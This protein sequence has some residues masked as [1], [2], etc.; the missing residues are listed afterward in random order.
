M[1]LL[2]FFTLALLTATQIA[3]ILMSRQTLEKQAERRVVECLENTPRACS[4]LKGRRQELLGAIEKHKTWKVET[5]GLGVFGSPVFV[6]VRV[7]DTFSADLLCDTNIAVFYVNDE[8]NE[9]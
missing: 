5:V 1:K 9:H 4:S 8:S 6:R 7:G 3:I 2:A